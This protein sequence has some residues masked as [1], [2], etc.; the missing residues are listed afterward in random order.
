MKCE[1]CGHESDS[2]GKKHGTFLCSVC[3]HFSPDDKSDFK[4]YI[5]E[6][7]D[8][9]VLKT[10]RKHSGILSGMFFRDI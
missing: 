9:S 4:D 3:H 8:G 7:I 6:K 2:N 10:F 1:K 5:N